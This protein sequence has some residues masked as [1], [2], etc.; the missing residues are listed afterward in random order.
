[1]PLLLRIGHCSSANSQKLR[2]TEIK[3]VGLE[4]TIPT[5]LS[6]ISMY[7]YILNIAIRLLSNS[8][9]PFPRPPSIESTYIELETM[10]DVFQTY[11]LKLVSL[12]F[13]LRLYTRPNAYQ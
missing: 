5:S 2:N 10:R 12:P 1:M 4:V 7:W 9:P 11:L 8:S 6:T 13:K 3:S